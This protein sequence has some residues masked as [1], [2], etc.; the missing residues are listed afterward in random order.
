[1]LKSKLNC[2]IQKFLLRSIHTKMEQAPIIHG[3]R[4]SR[5]RDTADVKLSKT[6]S[7]ILRHSATKENLPIGSD[8]Y[9]AVSVLLKHQQFQGKKFEDIV[10]VVE[11]NSKSRFELEYRGDTTDESQS[12]VKTDPQGWWI[13]A[14]QGHSIEVENLALEQI[15]DSDKCP[16]AVHGTYI[17]SWNKAIKDQGLSKM[18]R[19]HIHL[20]T[21]LADE[22]GV[23]SGMRGS[24]SVYIYIDVAKAM[25]DGIKFYKSTNGVVLTEGQG[26]ILQPKYFKQVVSKDGNILR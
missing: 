15:V 17:S 25:A 5:A 11:N 19:N 22:S 8:G 3:K 20:A 24:A 23:I 18:A 26:G 14:N 12:A 4:Q 16:V 6:L 21:G 2:L 9:I 13:K 10:R 1:M 7:R